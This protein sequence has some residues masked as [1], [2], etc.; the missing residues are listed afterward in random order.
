MR[1]HPI[2]LSPAARR[3]AAAALALV[4]IAVAWPGAA[5]AQ[6]L[7]QLRAQGVVGER[8]DGYAV[9]RAPPASAQAQSFVAGVNAKRRAIY[10]SRAKQQN[11]TP[12]AVGQIYAKQIFERAPP[13]TWFL[14]ASGKWVRK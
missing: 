7:D 14:D 12:A 9:V 11:V 10:E 6:S 8:Y 13:G 3:V 1:A 5:A 2:R 4:L